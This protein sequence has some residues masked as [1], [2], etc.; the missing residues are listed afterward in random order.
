MIVVSVMYVTTQFCYLFHFLR[1]ISCKTTLYIVKNV[2]RKLTRD[3]P[4]TKG[5]GAEQE[6]ISPNVHVN[7]FELPVCS[8]VKTG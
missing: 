8:H 4:E 1:L 2:Y 7:K 6:L 5:G 3:L